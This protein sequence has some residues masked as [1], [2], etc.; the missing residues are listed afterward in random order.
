MKVIQIFK[1]PTPKTVQANCF[2]G[3]NPDRI[4][5]T[6]GGWTF[7][8]KGATC[9]AQEKFDCRTREQWSAEKTE[10]CCTN[11]GM[12][13]TTTTTTA[14]VGAEDDPHMTDVSGDKFDLYNA[15]RQ[16]FLVIPEGASKADADLLIRG[17]V[18]QHG[19]RQNDLWIRN[20]AISGKWVPGGSYHFKTQ[21]G[22][23]ND[24]ATQLMRRS[25]TDAWTNLDDVDDASL[26]MTSSDEKV[27]PTADFEEKVTRK[28]V[29]ATGSLKV[30]VDF[31][32]AQKEGNDVNHLDL[33]VEGL[34]SIQNA[35]GLLAGEVA[36]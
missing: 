16:T 5:V 8:S 18:K 34:A 36:S 2:R 33:H 9:I 12:G 19:E 4:Y 25:N 15:G 13:C 10:W 35:G 17:S 6:Q 22:E 30:H 31:G 23:F 20:L 3:N 27:A 26:V 21:D 7:T 14:N 29:L 11:K 24:P 32:T 28:V 1:R